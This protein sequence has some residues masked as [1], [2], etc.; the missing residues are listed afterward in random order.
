[1]SI[2][3]R[4][5]SSRDVYSSIRERR[6]LQDEREIEMRLRLAQQALTLERIL[7]A[8]PDSSD[9]NRRTSN[10]NNYQQE[11]DA[12]FTIINDR[13]IIVYLTELHRK[14]AFPFGAFSFIF[15]AVSLGFLAK[16]SGQTVGFIFGVLISV[17]Y[18]CMVF[19]GQTMSLRMVFPPFWSM[20]A[21]N[22]LSLAIGFV[23]AIIRVRK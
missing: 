23:L 22:L 18:W 14:F 20:W 12:L 2:T 1:M 17:I 11:V 15:L 16:K 8:G 4:E 7:R 19:I 21:A 6:S 9:W 3:P 10:F 13:S 5:M